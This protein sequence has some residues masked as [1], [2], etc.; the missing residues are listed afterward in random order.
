METATLIITVVCAT[1]E[2]VSR[3]VPTSKTW[4]IIGNVISV[5]NVVSTALDVKKKKGA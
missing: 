4:S 1:Y 5:L 2:V 3:V